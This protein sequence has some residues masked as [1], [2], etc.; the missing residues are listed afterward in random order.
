MS[1]NDPNGELSILRLEFP[2]HLIGEESIMGRVRFVARRRS[3]GTHPHTVITPDLGEMRAA[4]EAG[5]TGRV[6]QGDG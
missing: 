4:L 5:R 3:E 1:G 2:G 6:R